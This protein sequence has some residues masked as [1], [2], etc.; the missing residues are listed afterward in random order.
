MCLFSQVFGI[1]QI[2]WFGYL[3][4]VI[5][6]QSRAVKHSYKMHLVTA[7]VSWEENRNCMCYCFSRL[8]EFFVPMIVEDYS[9]SH[10]REE[11]HGEGCGTI[12]AKLFQLLKPFSDHVWCCKPTVF[13]FVSYCQFQI[14]SNTDD[15]EWRFISFVDKDFSLLLIQ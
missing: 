6:G 8:G 7:G 5:W 14:I 3:G 15:F 9:D 4:I 1:F 12:F 11:E 13:C 2:F 10:K